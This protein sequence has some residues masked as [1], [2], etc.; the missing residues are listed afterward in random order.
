[1]KLIYG[2]KNRENIQIKYEILD[3]NIGNVSNDYIKEY[4]SKYGETKLKINLIY[5][6]DYDKIYN[7]NDIKHIINKID[8]LYVENVPVRVNIPDNIVIIWAENNSKI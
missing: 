2:P 7:I 6:N 5:K 1:M 4:R 8:L 3:C